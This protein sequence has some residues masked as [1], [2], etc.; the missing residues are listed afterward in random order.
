M[1][2]LAAIG[3]KTHAQRDL[4]EQLYLKGADRRRRVVRGAAGAGKATRQR[5][6][7][8]SPQPPTGGGLWLSRACPT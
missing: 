6:L 5:S 4:F 1:P 8:H 3:G 7:W 2:Y